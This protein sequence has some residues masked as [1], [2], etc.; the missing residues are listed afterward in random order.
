MNEVFGIMQSLIQLPNV[1]QVSLVSF[2]SLQILSSKNCKNLSKISIYLPSICE[3]DLVHRSQI[4]LTFQSRCSNANFTD[5]MFS[6]FQKS[7]FTLRNSN[8][9]YV[10]A[11]LTRLVLTGCTSISEVFLKNLI[12]GS[13]AIQHLDLQ[14]CN[15]GPQ[16]IYVAV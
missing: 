6:S 7:Y 3:L 8:T 13:K 4:F 16:V 5:G 2:T 11:N 10:V 15:V 1:T 14:E 9:D 12:S